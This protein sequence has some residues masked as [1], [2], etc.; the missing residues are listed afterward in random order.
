MESSKGDTI[1]QEGGQDTGKN[2]RPVS[3]LCVSGMVCERIIA[4][5]I[6]DFFEANA[7]F[8][9]FQFGFRKNKS[10]TSELLTLFDNLMEA[11]EKKQ[12]VAL[13]LYDLSAAFDTVDPKILLQKMKLYGFNNKAMSWISSFLTG[14]RQAVKIKEAVSELVSMEIGTPQGSRLSPLLF[15]I[16]MADLDLWTK[17]SK[18]SNFADDTQSIIIEDTREN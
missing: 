2:Y 13:V 7:L 10:T 5:Q 18:L 4:V 6:E 11:K 12:E 9:D 14:R 17:D 8:G 15:V 3:L 1:A 16:L